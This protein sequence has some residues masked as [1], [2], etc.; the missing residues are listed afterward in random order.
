MSFGEYFLALVLHI[1]TAIIVGAVAA[2]IITGCG[3]TSIQTQDP[4][5]CSV[6]QTTTGA[7][8]TCP[9]GSTAHLENGEDGTDGQDGT[10][11]PAS[12]LLVRLIDDEFGIC[13]NETLYRI[14]TKHGKKLKKLR[15]G[16]VYKSAF[17]RTRKF[18][19]LP[20]CVTEEIQ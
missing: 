13:M 19:V 15:P 8:I 10:A 7:D 5:S 11:L 12:R 3:P 4:E 17:D 6:T 9:D 2:I 20:D 16:K 14:H 1:F 18:K